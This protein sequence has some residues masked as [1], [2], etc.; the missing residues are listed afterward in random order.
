M[1]TDWRK[2]S[3][4]CKPERLGVQIGRR[5]LPIFKTG[6]A[7]PSLKSDL[8]SS[9]NPADEMLWLTRSHTSNGTATGAGLM[10]EAFSQ[11][12]R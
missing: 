7:Y 2:R 11:E 9:D 6:L 5:T 1:S 12:T 8:S 10:A 4:F 3:R